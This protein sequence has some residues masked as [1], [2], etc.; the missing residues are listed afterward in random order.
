MFSRSKLIRGYVFK[1]RTSSVACKLSSCW[2]GRMP[3]LGVLVGALQ[4]DSGPGVHPLHPVACMQQVRPWLQGQG[5]CEVMFSVF[6]VK[7]V[8]RLLRSCFK[9]LFLLVVLSSS[10]RLTGCQVFKVEVV[11][12][13]QDDAW[14]S[15][16]CS[17]VSFIR[18]KV[19]Q[20]G[21][22]G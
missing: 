5:C 22:L 20:E 2:E 16:L 9:V 12:K 10:S 3:E 21:I 7:A 14:K 15:C 17:S 19:N 13:I 8:I 11:F 6:K 1:V 18:I 4:L